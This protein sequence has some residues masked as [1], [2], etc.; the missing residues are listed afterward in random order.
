VRATIPVPQA[1]SSTAWPG[2]IPATST[3]WRAHSAKRAGTKLDSYTSAASTESW[4]VSTELVIANLLGRAFRP[5]I[6][7][8]TARSMG[9]L[10]HF[11]GR[12]GLPYLAP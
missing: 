2:A 5:T 11:R 7:P 1:T 10:P 12:V 9:Q 6:A 8:A 3:R 4:K